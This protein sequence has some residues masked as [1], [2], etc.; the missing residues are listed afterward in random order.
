MDKWLNLK[1]FY[2]IEYGNHCC[3]VIVSRC[4]ILL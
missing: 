3:C 1:E 4:V 2:G